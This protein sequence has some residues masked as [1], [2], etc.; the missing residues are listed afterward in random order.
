MNGVWLGFWLVMLGQL[1]LQ[2][3]DKLGN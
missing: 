2:A 1:R 3:K